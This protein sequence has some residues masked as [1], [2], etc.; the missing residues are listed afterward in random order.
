MTDSMAKSSPVVNPYV[1]GNPVTGTEMFFGREDI[2]EFV[3]QALIGQ[4]QDN[5]IV[6]HGE[7]RTG[8]TSVLYHMRRRIDP[9]YIPVLIDLQGLSMEGMATF[10]WEIA[11]TICRSLRRDL[12]IHIQRPSIEDLSV[13]SREFFESVFLNRVWEAIG[14]RHL[15]L[16]FDESVRLE[17]QVLAGRLERDIFDYL[18]HLMQ[19]NRRLNFIFS[20][21]SRLE[22]IQREFAE[23]F[24]VARYKKISFLDP[25]AAR[26]LITNPVKGLF[27]YEDGALEYILDVSGSN[28]YYTQLIC[29]SL[30]AR[31]ERIRPNL[32]TVDDVK[33]VL[34]E[35]VERG[36]PNLNFIWDQANPIEKLVL[37]AM[38]ELMKDENHA[39]SEHQIE[40][41]LKENRIAL[42]RK[43]L[44]TALVQLISREA[45]IEAGN[46]RFSVDLLRLYLRDQRRIEWVLEELND[47]VEGMRRADAISAPKVKRPALMWAYSSAAFVV[48]IGALLGIFV[49]PASPLSL[50]GSSVNLPAPGVYPNQ[51]CG[52]DPAGVEAQRRAR[53]KLCVESVEVN[54]D[55]TA[56]FNVSWTAEIAEDLIVEGQLIDRLAKQS[57]LGNVNMYITDN[58][59]N[60]YD[61]IDLGGA[62]KEETIILN[63]ETVMGWFLPPPTQGGRATL[64]LSR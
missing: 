31:W 62:A 47:A 53:V 50:L 29:H 18:R 48:V 16:M 7:R 55:G 28:A 22:E 32:I 5:I 44:N 42:S 63:R 64:Y 35:V 24:N 17:D 59:G 15:L 38:A 9:R 13:S 20:I 10:L 8:K 40:E 34:L 33:A 6:L 43:E 14:D 26:Q 27:G 25:E 57:D 4:H 45:I 46:Y 37:V 51:R 36:A 41:V 49:I 60:R 12:N 3:Q 30:F 19:H 58:R 54:P 11:T 1:A 21:G 52:I 39:V 23:L 61:F 56:K 2:F